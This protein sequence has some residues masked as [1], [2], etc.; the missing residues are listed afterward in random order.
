MQLIVGNVVDLVCSLRL[1][2][3]SEIYHSIFPISVVCRP[4]IGFVDI[5][6]TAGKHLETFDYNYF[7]ER[8][9]TFQNRPTS[10]VNSRWCPLCH[11]TFT[12]PIR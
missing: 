7:L 6:R 8:K 11:G 4:K 12:K 10:F 2:L 5:P 3:L 1:T 9:K